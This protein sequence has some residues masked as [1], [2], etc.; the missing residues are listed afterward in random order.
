MPQKM[1]AAPLSNAIASSP[2]LASL[3]HLISHPLLRII[4]IALLALYPACSQSDESI[5]QAAPGQYVSDYITLGGELTELYVAIESE[6]AFLNLNPKTSPATIQGNITVTEGESWQITV[7]CTNDGYMSEY[8]EAQGDYVSGGNRLQRPATIR[9]VGG[10]A[11]DLSALSSNSTLISGPGDA[12]IPIT[13]TQPVSW[14]DKIL[15]EGRSYR[16]TITLTEDL[17]E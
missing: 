10:N 7:S 14:S 4:L 6:S 3:S 17:L 13:I 8:D 1:L 16:M 15:A 5:P 9:A 12:N 11:L 2:A